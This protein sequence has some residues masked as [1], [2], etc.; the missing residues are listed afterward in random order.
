MKFPSYIK[1]IGQKVVEDN[2]ILTIKV[3]WWNP[4]LWWEVLKYCLKGVNK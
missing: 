3:T 2:I 1:I 4:M